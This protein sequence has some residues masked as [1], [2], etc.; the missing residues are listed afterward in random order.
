MIVPCVL[1]GAHVLP[2][3]AASQRSRTLAVAS[4]DRSVIWSSEN[5][6]RENGGGAFGTGCV[7]AATSPSR[8][9]GGTA[10]SSIGNSGAPVSRSNT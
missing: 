6:C 7:A 10:C 2:R 5:S 3:F 1:G 4:G 8:S 9:D